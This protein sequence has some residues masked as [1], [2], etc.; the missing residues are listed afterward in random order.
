MQ[1]SHVEFSCIDFNRHNVPLLTWDCDVAASAQAWADRG[2]FEHSNS[3]D[4]PPP[5][6]PAGENLGMGQS[7]G[8]QVTDNWYSEISN[9]AWSPGDGS[10]NSGTTGHFTALVWKGVKKLGC[11][12]YPPTRIWVCRYKSDDTLNDNSA[13]MAGIEYRFPSFVT[14]D[15]AGSGAYKANVLPVT[16]PAG[17]CAVVAAA[18]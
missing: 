8:T 10:G 18:S 4:I 16:K 17:T 7:S 12:F 6:G 11:G 15:D 13:N 9:W 14:Y 3:Y 2:V 1:N 5:A